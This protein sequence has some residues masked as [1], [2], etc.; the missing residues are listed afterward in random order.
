KQ[1]IDLLSSG[2]E[3]SEEEEIIHVVTT[4]VRSV[5][6]RTLETK[7]EE[8]LEQKFARFESLF[9]EKL[10]KWK[11]EIVLVTQSSTDQITAASMDN[12]FSTERPSFPSQM[13]YQD[14]TPNSRMGN[15]SYQF[16]GSVPREQDYTRKLPRIR[17]EMFDGRGDPLEFLND[18]ETSAAC[19]DFNDQQTIYAFI[20]RL[21]SSAKT[22]FGS[23]FRGRINVVTWE[24]VK[25]EFRHHYNTV[26]YLIKAETELAELRYRTSEDIQAFLWKYERLMRYVEG[27]KNNEN[28]RRYM[29][30]LY[31][32]M[33][34]EI[35]RM[36][37][38]T[39]DATYKEISEKIT[40][41]ATTIFL[42]SGRVSQQRPRAFSD[43]IY[44][45]DRGRS[46]SRRSLSREK[47]ERN[48]Q[49]KASSP[50]SDH[51]SD[52]DAEI[53]STEIEKDRKNFLFV[54][55]KIYGKKIEALVDTGAETSAI[56]L[57]DIKDIIEK[58]R[59]KLQ[60]SH[61]YIR[62][63]DTRQ[64]KPRVGRFPITVFK[65][66]LW[67]SSIVSKNMKRSMLIGMDILG[68]LKG[69]LVIDIEKKAI[70][71]TAKRKVGNQRRNDSVPSQLSTSNNQGTTR[72]QTPN[73][74]QKDEQKQDR[75]HRHNKKAVVG[76][77]KTEIELYHIGQ[78]DTNLDFDKMI[79]T[80]DFRHK[81]QLKKVLTR[82]QH[83][84]AKSWRD[85]KQIKKAVH[86]IDTGNETPSKHVPYRVPQKYKKFLEKEI[87]DMLKAGII[88]ESNG[89]WA[90]PVFVIPKKDGTA[91]MVIDYRSLNEK[92]KKDAYPIP[93]MDEC[94]DMLN[95]AKY[96][97][98]IDLRSGYYQ[99]VL[100]PA[101]QE[102]AAFVTPKGL[103]KPKRMMFGL[104][105]APSTF[106]REM[107]KIFKEKIGSSVLVYI[108]DIMV[109]S[110]TFEKQI[111]DLI[112]V[113][114]ICDEHDIRLAPNKC[115]FGAQEVEF[116][117]HCVSGEV[118]VQFDPQRETLL[119]VDASSLGIGVILAQLDDKV[120]FKDDDYND[121]EI[122]AIEEAQT[123]IDLN[124][125]KQLQQRD[126][127]CMG[128]KTKLEQGRKITFT[129]KDDVV[130]KIIKDDGNE[131]LLIVVPRLFRKQILQEFHDSTISGH[132][133]ALKTK[134]KIEHNFWW[135]QLTQT[136]RRYVQ[137]CEECQKLKSPRAP[138]QG[139]LEP[140]KPVSPWNRLSIDIL[141]ELPQT[142][143][144]NRWI[145][146]AQD[147]FTK[148][149]EIKAVSNIKA[150]TVADFILYN[151]ILRH[152]TPLHL[153]SDR[154][155]QF[156]S[157]LIQ[158]LCK[159]MVI[160][161]ISTAPYKPSTNGQVERLN[162][163]LVNCLAK[164]TIKN[165]SE[166]DNLLPFI[167]WSLNTAIQDSTKFSPY[168]I[169][170][171]RH[172][173]FPIDASVTTLKDLP[174]DCPQYI[175]DLKQIVEET[176]QL[177][178]DNIIQRQERDRESYNK[179][180]TEVKFQPG[181]VVLVKTDAIRQGE[182]AKLRSKWSQKGEIIEMLPN[183]LAAKIK[184]YDSNIEKVISIKNLKYY[185]EQIDSDAEFESESQETTANS[186]NVPNIPERY[187]QQEPIDTTNEMDLIQEL[188][189]RL[190]NNYA[191]A[192]RSERK[193][194][195]S[196]YISNHVDDSQ[197]A[198]IR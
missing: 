60:I 125:F 24:E 72:R 20:D 198:V 126:E 80:K 186:N 196:N 9:M 4:R 168:F 137:G 64:E 44:Q 120:T 56:K 16:S 18:F 122:Y 62:T 96:F 155:P 197:E 176:N 63:F 154:G 54:T 95:G 33:P 194:Q 129:I 158:E 106:Q 121:T 66:Q 192:Q 115:T 50:F 52:N 108:D 69:N 141:G 159:L 111:Q 92:T 147:S 10:N 133:S 185:F 164:F 40:A 68:K 90:A 140:T 70:K 123:P 53:Y 85:N 145:I 34:H 86:I 39:A 152:G 37:P 166:W 118:V 32:V 127:F 58:K 173:V 134:E 93:R 87:D 91:R 59:I 101:S 138:I 144:G 38:L 162:Q 135:P 97:S 128:I 82:N 17:M 113:F 65:Q 150:S 36:V 167:Q 19:Y 169:N 100:D 117:G 163:T 27:P 75:L 195:G 76:K 84:F 190:Q 174:P 46:E 26:A 109:Y 119:K 83:L 110:A 55:V 124:Q 25:E 112:D 49:Q 7:I 146:V 21:T 6:D 191:N 181:D 172:P 104:A 30:G 61:R 99:F 193:D 45:R 48:Q 15:L 3:K 179:N 160:K 23:K 89:P 178:K 131:K 105:N 170:H 116:L 157:N 188:E 139:Y 103:Y 149:C 74:Q 151:V 114:R 51:K 71:L 102:K 180:K 171:G 161:K 8:K 77:K 42:Q 184:F 81:E 78:E 107:D 2:M 130:Y 132:L 12:V 11:D 57:D 79:A 177:V 73:I 35:Q 1:R 13:S 94:L 156:M 189:K 136:V 187:N 88:E 67:T 165:H 175:E 5:L 98:V 47:F 43:S 28:D 142:D 29:F 148:W 183:Q 22:W 143:R 41:L 182:C 31:R 14:I 153:L